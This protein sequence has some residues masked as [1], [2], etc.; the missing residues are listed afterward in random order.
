MMRAPCGG[1]ISDFEPRMAA[2]RWRRSTVLVIRAPRHQ[3]E[4]RPAIEEPLGQDPRCFQRSS[5][6]SIGPPTGRFQTGCI[7]PRYQW[8]PPKKK[9][10]L[11]RQGRPVP[12]RYLAKARPLPRRGGLTEAALTLMMYDRAGNYCRRRKVIHRFL[13]CG[14][15]HQAPCDR[16]RFR[17][18][19][20][21]VSTAVRIV[22]ESTLSAHRPRRHLSHSSP[23]RRP[24]P[25]ERRP[26]LQRNGR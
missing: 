4:Q 1:L 10:P 6:L 5:A 11:R 18:S 7:T 2:S 24:P 22:S 15:R 20:I 9:Q 19:H 17:Q 8:V 23:A 16:V 13:A 26:L 12:C 3:S 25:L 21:P 14:F